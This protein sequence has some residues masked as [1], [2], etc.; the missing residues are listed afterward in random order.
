MLFW[1][2]AA[3]LTVFCVAAALFPLVRNQMANV[4]DQAFDIEV[5]KDQLGEI[6]RDETHGL[7]SAR[8]WGLQ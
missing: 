2:A 6:G 7:I 4:G 1:V 8:D 3:V 5:Y